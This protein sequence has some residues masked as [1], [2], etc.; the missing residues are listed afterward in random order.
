MKEKLDRKDNFKLVMTLGEGAFRMGH[1]PG[2][3]NIGSMGGAEG[4]ISPDDEIV[5]YC[6]DENCPA[7]KSAYQMLVD[8]G[9]AKVGR[10]AGGIR[11]WH[12]AGYPIDTDLDVP[13]NKFKTAALSQAIGEEDHV[14]GRVDAPV[15]LV[16]YGDYECPYTRRTMAHVHQSRIERDLNS[17]LESGVQGIP[18]LFINGVRYDGDLK[19]ADIMKAIEDGS[20]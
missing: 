3:I 5:V 10:F 7:S 4:V 17:G 8:H 19:L 18:T 11:A 6:H 13:L 12:E 20:R 2:S 1:I 14:Q 16:V 9:F 15:T